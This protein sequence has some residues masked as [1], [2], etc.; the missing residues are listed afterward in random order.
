MNSWDTYTKRMEAR[1]ASKR[2]AV[3]IREARMLSS[4]MKN[5][6][7]YFEVII[8]GINRN[9]TI[10]NSDNMNEKIMCSL[11]GEDFACGELVEWADNYWLITEKD[12]NNELY[13]R[14]KLLQ[15]NYLLKWIDDDD[16]IHEQW[17]FIEDGTK[18]L[19]GEYEDRNF[20]VTRGDSRIGMTIGR[21]QYTVKFERENR[22]IIDDPM[23]G[24]RKAYMLTKPLK[25]GKTYN[26]QGVFSFVLQEG[27]STDNDNKELGIADY[28]KHFP[29]SD[30][31]DNGDENVTEN[32]N[33]S[34]GDGK[35]VWL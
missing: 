23:S 28:Y 31:T 5:S 1:G 8:N 20:V 9:V 22:F 12:A 16:I 13:T 29:K 7:S 18:Y 32:D 15:C 19:I 17:C 27:V 2:N 3:L 21:N 24:D 4:K 11:P 35:K 34:S 10:I 25:V 33:M 26:N 30:N 6:L 14:V